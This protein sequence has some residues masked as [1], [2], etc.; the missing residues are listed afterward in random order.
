MNY[1]STYYKTVKNLTRSI[2]KKKEK[3]SLDKCELL[4]VLKIN[5]SGIGWFN[6]IHELQHSIVTRIFIF[7]LSGSKMDKISKKMENNRDSIEQV[8]DSTYRLLFFIYQ[9]IKVFR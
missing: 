7:F 4:N 2:E 5:F 8:R 9:F 3:K 1:Y 6:F